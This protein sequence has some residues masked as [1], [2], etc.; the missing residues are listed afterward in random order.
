MA[1]LNDRLRAVPF[2]R[3]LPA[4][5]LT[6]IANRLQRRTVRKG[7]LLFREGDR[8]DAMFLIES[9]ELEVMHGLGDHPVAVLGA[10]SFAG[11]L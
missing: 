5:E 8:A 11:E 9:G 4:R 1:S 6:A 7:A 3:G 10:G 2:F